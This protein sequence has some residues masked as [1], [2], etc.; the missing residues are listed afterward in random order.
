M[1]ERFA[2][3]RFKA[4]LESYYMKRWIAVYLLPPFPFYIIPLMWLFGYPVDWRVSS[5]AIIA[6]GMKA[7]GVVTF[8]HIGIGILAAGSIAL[9]VVAAGPVGIGI[10][11]SGI[12]SF[13]VFAF[14]VCPVGCIAIGEFAIGIVAVGRNA[15]GIYSLSYRGKGGGRYVFSTHRQDV[16]AVAFFTRWLPKLKDA[17]SN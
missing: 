11:A 7:I 8:G 4:V 5:V 6:V 9:G 17:F 14:G 15:I 13:G 3:E 16:E 12:L 2:P 1:S 10:C